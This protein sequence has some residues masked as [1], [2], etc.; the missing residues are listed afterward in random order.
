MIKV[1]PRTLHAK[2]VYCIIKLAYSITKVFGGYAKEEFHRNYKEFHKSAI[3]FRN[4]GT[5]EP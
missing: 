4:G 2:K 5:S 1:Y 3:L